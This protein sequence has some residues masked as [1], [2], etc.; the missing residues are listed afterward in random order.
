ME[1]HRHC[2]RFSELFLI[3]GCITWNRDAQWKARRLWVVTN[4]CSCLWFW[5]WLQSRAGAG[6]KWL[7]HLLGLSLEC[8]I[9]WK[10]PV[11]LTL[12]FALYNVVRMV[13]GDRKC[14][15]SVCAASASPVLPPWRGRSTGS[16]PS[17]KGD[18]S[19]AGYFS[20]ETQ[21]EE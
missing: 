15:S 21:L 7:D 5:N 19:S 18:G 17:C 11:L 13:R 8:I 1:V 16:N 2:L 14:Q 9:K 6:L 10:R 3:F 4:G 12:H 20:A